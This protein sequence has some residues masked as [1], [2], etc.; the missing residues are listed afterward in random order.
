MDL[1]FKIKLHNDLDSYL[2]EQII[3]CPICFFLPDYFG[4]QKNQTVWIILTK[5][6]WAASK[7]V[8]PLFI[9]EVPSSV[10]LLFPEVNNDGWKPRQ[11]AWTQSEVVTGQGKTWKWS[12][13]YGDAG[14]I[15][16]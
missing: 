9:P 6:I 10:R 7:I 1:L 13:I 3:L 16:F 15:L 12:P 11:V 8:F 2:V 4:I 5:Q 14:K